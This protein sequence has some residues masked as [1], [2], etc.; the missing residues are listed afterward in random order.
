[1]MPFGLKTTEATYQHLINKVF[2]T[3][4]E[5]TMEVYMDG[6][7]TKSVKEVRIYFTDYESEVASVLRVTPHC[8]F[9]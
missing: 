2:A 1:M 7:I 5:K 4:I 3:L 8:C 6:M 9:D